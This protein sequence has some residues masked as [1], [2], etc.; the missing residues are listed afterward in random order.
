[1]RLVKFDEEQQLVYAEVY[2]PGRPDSQGHFMNRETIRKMAHTFLAKMRTKQ[3]NLEHGDENVDAVVVESFVAR[4]DDPVFIAHSWVA[5]VH[6]ADAE[7]WEGV[8]SG[9]I[10]GFSLEGVGVKET[11]LL[12][13]SVPEEISVATES[14]PNGH[15][16]TASLHFDDEGNL[17]EGRTDTAQ[18]GH[19]HPIRRGTI[20]EEGQGANDGHTHRFSFMEQLISN[21]S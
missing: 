8:K 12:E 13:I 20:T 9:E 17:V 2:S 15:V 5:G 16:H 7:L 10:N 11:K 14:G 6:I 3:V 21:V 4:D 19:W 1:M 18:D